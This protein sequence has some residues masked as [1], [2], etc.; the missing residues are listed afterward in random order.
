IPA[1]RSVMGPIEA[2]YRDRL[3]SA[4][5]ARLVGLTRSE[6]SAA[7]LGFVGQTIRE[8][9]NTVRL[10]NALD[11][12]LRGDKIETIA[13]VVGYRSRT[14]FYRHFQKVTGLT[15][16]ALRRASARRASHDDGTAA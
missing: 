13:M 10:R 14:T 4:V 9:I 2:N 16:A 1:I 6:L 3:T 5:L 7:F 12:V 8:Y 15:P 11:K